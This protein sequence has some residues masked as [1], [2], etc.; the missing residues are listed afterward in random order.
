MIAMS[1]P[2]KEVVMRTAEIEDC[3]YPFKWDIG[4]RFQ[5][6]RAVLFIPAWFAAYTILALFWLNS[7]LKKAES[8]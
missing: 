4:W 1:L 3:V 6:K 7:L 8:N 2:A 5:L